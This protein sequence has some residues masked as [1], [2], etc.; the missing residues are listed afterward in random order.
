MVRSFWKI[1]APL[2]GRTPTVRRRPN[3]SFRPSVSLL[4][5]RSMP[6]VVMNTLDSGAGSLRATIATA[7]GSDHAVTF[8]PAVTG[9]ITLS[10]EIAIS[11]AMTITG[12]GAG[13]LTISGGD[14]SRIFNFDA[15]STATVSGLT[16]TH[17]LAGPATLLIPDVVG[18]AIMSQGTLTVN[19][20]VLSNNVATDPTIIAR[21]G[22]IWSNNLLTLNNDTFINNSADDYGGAVAGL[23]SA[24][25]GTAA[26]VTATN[27]YFSNNGSFTGGAMAAFDSL[28][29]SGDFFN[30]NGGPLDPT[31]HLITR[32]NNG[33]NVSAWNGGLGTTPVIAQTIDKTTMAGGLAANG[34]GL[35]YFNAIALSLTNSTV[36]GNDAFFGGGIYK[37]NNASGLAINSDTITANN[38]QATG[39]G[40]FNLDGPLVLKN[41]IVAGNTQGTSF[42]GP[43]PSDITG[44]VLATATV[45]VPPSTTTS[46]HNLIGDGNGLIAVTNTTVGGTTTVAFVNLNGLNG[47]QVGTAASPINAGLS[48]LRSNGGPAVGSDG[49][50]N[51][52]TVALL[53]NSPAIGGGDPNVTGRT[54]DENGTARS[55][56]NN[57]GAIEYVA[58]TANHV[59]FLIQPTTTPAGQTISSFVVEVVDQFGNLVNNDST[60]TVTLSIG[61][62]PSG[63]SAILSGTLTLTFVNGVAT[64]SDLSID[65]AGTGYTLHATASG[66]TP[67]IDSDP[68]DIT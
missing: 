27:C 29:L 10:S 48:D 56:T 60:D 55:A 11:G 9:T 67:D 68:F 63:G 37:N 4:E 38:A 57:I 2:T 13:S 19:N 17:G 61:T 31:T 8:A 49:A 14:A 53:A 15:S 40:I 5:D 43:A 34:G 42:S 62:D 1:F 28:N 26:S 47:N 52:K 39:G 46:D 54:T 65:T 23:L 32:G 50:F 3:P 21:G 25:G 35:Y 7:A 45:D 64:F 16:L 44:T 30:S 22:A 18:G 41:T 33:G 36:Y 24:G 51:L 12:P 20:C 59:I 6:S 66:L 58:N